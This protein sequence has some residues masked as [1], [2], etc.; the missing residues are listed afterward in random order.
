MNKMHER[1]TQRREELG[2][3]KSH[4]AKLVGISAPTMGHW[5]SG[6][7]KKIEGNNLRNLAN[8]LGVSSD[9]ILTGKDKKEYQ[10]NTEPGPDITGFVP[11]ISWVQAGDWNA[12]ADPYEMGDGEGFYPCPVTHGHHTF[13]L[14]VRGA[15]MEPEYHDGDWIYVDPDKQYINGSHVVVRQEDSDEATFKR[16]IIEGD[17]MLLEAI[18]PHWPERIVP[19]NGD[20]TIVGVVIFSGKPR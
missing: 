18:N 16:L 6:E 8:A 13:I 14:K 2:L 20:A 17:K 12:A 9:W 19:V 4:L 1:I 3:K 10:P 5:E 7:I 11:L 15:S